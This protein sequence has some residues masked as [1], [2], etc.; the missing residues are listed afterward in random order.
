[1]KK[2]LAGAVAVVVGAVALPASAQETL[3]SFG[4]TGQFAIDAQGATPLFVSPVPGGG[5]GE[6]YGL[7]PFIGWNLHKTSQPDNNGNHDDDKTSIFY[8]NPGVD[9]FVIDHLSIGGEVLFAITGSSVTHHRR[10]QP[11]VTNDGQ[12]GTHFGI[13]PRVG[14]DIPI[15]D[16]FSLWPRGGLG[17]IHSSYSGAGQPDI[18][19]TAWLFYADVYFCFHLVPNFFFGVGP[20]FTAS[21]SSSQSVGGASGD[22][23]GITDIRL[24]SFL[25]G[26]YL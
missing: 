17:F 8:I 12:G 10:N 6:G 5:Y 9:Y 4:A 16:K 19:G 26:W 3:N 18:S 21:V 22:G 7:T 2:I 15:G 25:I 1:M 11:D 23:P 13:L 24:L 20:G 14:Y